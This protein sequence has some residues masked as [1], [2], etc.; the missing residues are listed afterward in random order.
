MHDYTKDQMSNE[1]TTQTSTKFKHNKI[2]NITAATTNHRTLNSM[3]T[4]N[5]CS[6]FNIP[7]LKQA[8]S[9]FPISI[10]SMLNRQ[11]QLPASI[12]LSPVFYIL[13]SRSSLSLIGRVHLFLRILQLFFPTAIDFCS[14]FVP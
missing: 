9:L 8:V 7:A 6:V 14:A 10:N 12:T 3:K 13:N 11:L 4:K 5:Y 2:N 1:I